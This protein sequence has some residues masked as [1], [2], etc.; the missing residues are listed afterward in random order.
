[1]H[2]LASSSIALLS[3]MHFMSSSEHDDL[4]TVE[5]KHDCCTTLKFVSGLRKT[6]NAKL[7]VKLTAH[8]G[9][10]NKTSEGVGRGLSVPSACPKQSTGRTAAKSTTLGQSRIV[11]TRLKGLRKAMRRFGNVRRTASGVWRSLP[12]SLS[13]LRYRNLK[14]D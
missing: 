8:F 2:L 13:R 6:K 9:I 1:M 7:F 10:S 12:G 14:W 5:V 3:Q 4:D 11:A